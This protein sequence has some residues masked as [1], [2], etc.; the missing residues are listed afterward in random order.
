MLHFAGQFPPDTLSFV[1][2]YLSLFLTLSLGFS[3]VLYLYSQ[4]VLIHHTLSWPWRVT[5]R[6]HRSFVLFLSVLLNSNNLTS[7]LL[8]LLFLFHLLFASNPFIMMAHK[9]VL[10]KWI[11]ARRCCYSI[12]IRWTEREIERDIQMVKETAGQ[13]FWSNKCHS[14]PANIMIMNAIRKNSKCTAL[15]F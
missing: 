11:A 3:I 13:F 8:L 2:L 12:S 1:P 7:C 9:N 10:L 6:L 4:S 5:S 15:T 14:A